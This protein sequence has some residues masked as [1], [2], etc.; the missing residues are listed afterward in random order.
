LNDLVYLSAGQMD[1]FITLAGALLDATSHVV[2]LVN[3]GHVMPMLFRG[4][5]GA[6][7]DAMPKETG[8]LPMGIMDGQTYD[9]HQVPLGPGDCLLL[10]S[11]G[12]PDAV[13]TRGETF[14]LKGVHTALKGEGPHTPRGLG[15]RIVKAVKLHAAGRAQADD[16]TLM[17]VGRVS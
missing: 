2:T 6:I 3:A 7:E 15:E 14:G 17:C 10:F 8:G 13:S 16:I 1:R 9:A 12:V 11:D 4:A 5:T